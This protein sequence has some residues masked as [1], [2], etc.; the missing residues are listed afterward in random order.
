MI[1]MR[2]GYHITRWAA[3][4]IAMHWEAPVAGDKGSLLLPYACAE[5]GRSSYV[6][7]FGAKISSEWIEINILDRDFHIIEAIL[8]TAACGLTDMNPVCGPVTGAAEPC[9][10]HEGFN[11]GNCMV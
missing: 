6:T 5:I 9:C 7:E 1:S 11:E 2:T 10:I 3:N 8:T 4:G